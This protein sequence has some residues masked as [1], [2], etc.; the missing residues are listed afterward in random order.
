MTEYLKAVGKTEKIIQRQNMFE[1]VG[2]RM[3]RDTRKRWK[4]VLCPLRYC[5]RHPTLL[6]TR[7]H[8]APTEAGVTSVSR[9]SGANGLTTLETDTEGACR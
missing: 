5:H 6:N 8:T 1:F 7:P 4:D 3:R 2:L 9:H